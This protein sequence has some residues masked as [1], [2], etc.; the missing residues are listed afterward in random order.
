[1]ESGVTTQHAVQPVQNQTILN[2]SFFSIVFFFGGTCQTMVKTNGRDAGSRK[3]KCFKI[4]WGNYAVC[5]L[6]HKKAKNNHATRQH[7][8]RD[9]WTKGLGVNL[10]KT[11]FE[12]LMNPRSRY[13]M[14]FFLRVLFLLSCLLIYVAT[15]CFKIYLNTILCICFFK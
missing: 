5:L 8:T 13:S 14:A 9:N 1:M 10:A 15:S 3:A 4:H 12:K 6:S 7:Q 11:P 2:V